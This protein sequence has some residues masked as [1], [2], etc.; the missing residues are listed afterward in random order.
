MSRLILIAL[1]AAAAAAALLWGLRPDAAPAPAPTAGSAAL[2]STTDRS[3]P[4]VNGAPVVA[5]AMATTATTAGAEAPPP[6][7]TAEQWAQVEARLAG[8]PQAA[9]ERDRLRRYFAWSDAVQRWRGA[10]QDLALAQQV[11]AGLPERLAQA[12]VSAP[13][14]R[15]LKAALLQTLLPD[16]ASRTAALQAFDATLP[17]PAGPTPR[18]LEFQRRQ[19]A[20]V[21]AWQA[22]PASQRDPAA[23]Q[24]QIDA[25]RRSHFP[26]ETPR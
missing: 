16:D 21:A 19:S 11:D 4:A 13:E 15:L 2:E 1:L 23:L 26:K 12:E 5:T 18:D 14:A 20:L 22:Q 25:L 9:A 10:R 24:R 6:G 8:H 17:R 7:L 3:G